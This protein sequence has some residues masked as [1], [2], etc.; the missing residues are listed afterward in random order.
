MKL[1]FNNY[2]RYNYIYQGSQCATWVSLTTSKDY[3]RY[4]GQRLGPVSQ[5]DRCSGYKLLLK[6][7]LKA[8]HLPIANLF[9]FK[10]DYNILDS[11]LL[12]PN[13]RAQ[14]E[15]CFRDHF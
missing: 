13:L 5:V 14:I 8:G 15:Y 4:P 2:K 7:W 12:S 1:N 3:S 6:M 10:E 11:L 9:K